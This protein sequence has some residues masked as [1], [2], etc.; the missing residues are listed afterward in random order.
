MAEHASEK[1]LTFLRRIDFY[2]L[3]SSP[4]KVFSESFHAIQNNCTLNNKTHARH[5]MIIVEV[6]LP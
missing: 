2:H 4:V 1:R 6:T 5:W 3:A